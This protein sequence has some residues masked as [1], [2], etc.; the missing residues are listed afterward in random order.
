MLFSTCSQTLNGFLSVNLSKARDNSTWA[1][2]WLAELT[3]TPLPSPSFPPHRVSVQKTSVCG[4]KTSLCVPTPRPHVLTHAGVVPV[5]TGTFWIYTRR[6]FLRATQH[7]TPHGDRN[8]E[9]QKQRET[10]SNRE[11]DRERQRKRD[12]TRKEKTRQEKRRRDYKREE[13]RR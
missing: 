4:F 6:F 8:R 10:E 11:R 5:H 9:T 3:V 13:T 1:V 12:E 7:T 2:S